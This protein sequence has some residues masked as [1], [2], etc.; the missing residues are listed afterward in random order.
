MPVTTLPVAAPALAA[1][2]PPLPAP[3]AASFE[4]RWT[5]WLARGAA[6]DRVVDR[7]MT[8]L[9]VLAIV[10]GVLCLLLLR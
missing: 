9:A 1:S 5:A 2:A 4:E 10:A 6:H 3:G 8:F 7:R